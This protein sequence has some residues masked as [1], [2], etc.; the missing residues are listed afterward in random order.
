VVLSLLISR[1]TAFA[2]PPLLCHPFDI[3]NARS[4]PWDGARGWANGRADYNV[5]NLVRDTEELLTPS[6]PV[7][8]RMETLRRA[9]LYAS[10]DGEVAKQLLSA[11]NARARRSAGA[12]T[13]PLALFDAGYLTE[14]FRQITQLEGESEFRSAARTLRGAFD[15]ADGYALVKKSATMKPDEPALE[16]AAALI[17]L[18]V[19]R[20]SY[21]Q[22]ATKARQGTSKDSLLARNIKQLAL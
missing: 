1:G 17:A 4:L 12:N 16:F 7:I 8:V 22:H 5:K 18:G 11:L 10:R 6:T 19:E 14:T 21:P 15:N 13:D 9:A 2:G 20:A 3:G